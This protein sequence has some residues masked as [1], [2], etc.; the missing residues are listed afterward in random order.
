MWQLVIVCFVVGI[1]LAF[2][3]RRFYRAFKGRTN[4]CSCNCGPCPD[5]GNIK[6][7]LC[8]CGT[9]KELESRQQDGTRSTGES[10]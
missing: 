9:I 5:N 1:A 10:K 7:T 6:D 3:V 8:A 2:T 4:V